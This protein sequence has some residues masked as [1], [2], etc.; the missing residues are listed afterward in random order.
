MRKLG[1]VLVLI[2]LGAACGREGYPA[3]AKSDATPAREFSRA[4]RAGVDLA[5]SGP[6][7]GESPKPRELIT[8]EN[9][10]EKVRA[11]PE[12][13][14]PAYRVVSQ[15][16]KLSSEISHAGS[17]EERSRKS[18]EL[19]ELVRSDELRQAM[20]KVLEYVEQNDPECARRT[21]EAGRA[22]YERA[23][24]RGREIGRRITESQ[25]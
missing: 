24:Q 13:Y 22:A 10:E 3:S 4:C 18:A 25:P 12:E 16:G 2:L 21:R 5:L 11:L 9:V 1:P 7:P 23:Y 17:D 8:D 6:P 15:L 14:R 20:E 19:Q